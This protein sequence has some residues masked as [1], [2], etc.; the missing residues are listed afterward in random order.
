M[1]DI[2]TSIEVKMTDK[3]YCS[4]CHGYLSGSNLAI[5]IDISPRKDKPARFIVAIKHLREFLGNI[6]HFKGKNKAP[7]I[8]MEDI[9]D[10]NT[11]LLEEMKCLTC[12]RSAVE[13]VEE[14]SDVMIFTS[15][16]Q[17]YIHRNCL[18]TFRQTVKE[19]ID[20]TGG[21]FTKKHL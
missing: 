14:G 7:Y 3:N 21:E 10:M 8:F 12:G 15:T 4:F 18:D 11:F 2:E 1:E 20:K 17:G 5:I 19:K 13:S 16:P 6:K 9:H